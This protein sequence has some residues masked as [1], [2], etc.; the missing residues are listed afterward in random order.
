MSG[1]TS[2]S[3]SSNSAIITERSKN[4]GVQYGDGVGST[5]EEIVS[6]FLLIKNTLLAISKGMWTVKLCS[7]IIL[8]FFTQVLAETSEPVL[9]NWIL[10]Y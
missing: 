9:T 4:S 6:L 5:V 1:G 2:S 3:S 8:Q 10:F 7:N